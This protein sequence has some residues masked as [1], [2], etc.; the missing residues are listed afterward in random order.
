MT[1]GR[2]SDSNAGSS[3][4][5]MYKIGRPLFSRIVGHDVEPFRQRCCETLHLPQLEAVGLQRHAGVVCGT[6]SMNHTATAIGDSRSSMSVGT[7]FRRSG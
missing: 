7:T 4:F 3:R 1:K 2:T 6:I 5:P